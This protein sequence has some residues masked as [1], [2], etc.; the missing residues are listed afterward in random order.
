M[1]AARFSLHRDNSV[2]GDTREGYE[3]RRDDSSRVNESKIYSVSL[4]L[5]RI[6]V[7]K[8]RVRETIPDDENRRYKCSEYFSEDKAIETIP[9][10]GF[11]EIFHLSSPIL[12]HDLPRNFAHTQNRKANF[13][14]IETIPFG[15]FGEIFQLS[16]PILEHDLP[17]KF[18]H[19][20]QIVHGA[21]YLANNLVK[22]FQVQY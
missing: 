7:S 3:P 9:S 1:S 20:L 17:R 6:P 12:E 2:Y 22:L 11:G 10:G 16:S 21:E 19:P 14:T 18:A 15:E 4:F 8:R 5:A 13:A